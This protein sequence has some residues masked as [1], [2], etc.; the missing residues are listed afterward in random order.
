[1]WALLL[2]PSVELPMGRETLYWVG[3]T[4]V[5]GAT[6]A[7]GGAPYE[8]TKRCTRWCSGWGKRMWTLPLGPS[9]ELPTGPRIAT[10]GGGNACEC[11]HWDLRR[12]SF[13]SHE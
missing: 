2:G 1:M 3:E 8:T 12:S 10:L 6:G 9:V 7:F 13:W 5:D 11:S 4:H